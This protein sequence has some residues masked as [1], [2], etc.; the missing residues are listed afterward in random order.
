MSEPRAA[1]ASFRFSQAREIN[2]GWEGDRHR[3][4]ISMGADVD[5]LSVRGVN[6]VIDVS[7]LLIVPLIFVSFVVVAFFRAGARGFF[8]GEA[9]AAQNGEARFNFLG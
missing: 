3:T 2:H 7:L 5:L 4:F 1:E 8:N 6:C 9:G